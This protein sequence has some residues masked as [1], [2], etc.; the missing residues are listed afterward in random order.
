MSRGVVNEIIVNEGFRAKPYQDTLG[1]WTFGH[2]LTFITESESIR[3]VGERVEK[4]QFELASKLPYFDRLP[5]NVQDVLCEMA[6]QLG[7][8]GLLAFRKMLAYIENS[9]Y[10]DAA[11]EGLNSLWARQT[12]GRAKKMMDKL[13]NN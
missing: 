12:P 4:I 2:G 6:Y 3:I 7:V 10:D 5:V 11:V 13:K 8:T 1:V 9:Q